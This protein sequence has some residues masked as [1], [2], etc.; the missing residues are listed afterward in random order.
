MYWEYNIVTKELIPLEILDN[1]YLNHVKKQ[2]NELN[3][4]CSQLPD[5]E[6][7][8]IAKMCLV[9]FKSRKVNQNHVDFLVQ[10]GLLKHEGDTISVT[11]VLHNYVKKSLQNIRKYLKETKKNE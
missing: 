9:F 10:L 5:K 7:K 1:K 2:V 8:L 11:N 3:W 6:S 4:F